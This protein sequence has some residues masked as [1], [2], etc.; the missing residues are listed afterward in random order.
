MA[1]SNI[2]REPRREIIEQVAGMLFILAWAGWA[3]YSVH[4]STLI[5]MPSRCLD[6]T[7]TTYTVCSRLKTGY[8]LDPGPFFITIGLSLAPFTLYPFL[9]LMHAFGEMVCGWMRALG[10]DPRPKQRY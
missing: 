4:L 6:Y 9:L 10:L 1:L 5:Y 7:D 2:G 8:W 3:V